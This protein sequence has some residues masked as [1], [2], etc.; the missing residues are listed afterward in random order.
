MTDHGA[1]DWNGS[2]WTCPICGRKVAIVD[3]KLDVIEPG[4]TRAYHEGTA[5]G[6]FTRDW[7]QPFR[8]FLE[9]LH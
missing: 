1:M 5:K 7:L 3:G 8:N 4:N 2:H 6:A 9:G